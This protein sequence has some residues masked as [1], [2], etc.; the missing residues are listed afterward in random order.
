MPLNIVGGDL[1]AKDI[2]NVRTCC[3]LQIPGRDHINGYGGIC[4]ESGESPRS[5]NDQTFNVLNGWSKEHIQLR[6]IHW[7][8]NP[9]CH[10]SDKRE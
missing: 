9:L 2:V 5:Y 4:H 6:A 3:A 1:G 8:C 10:I 7:G